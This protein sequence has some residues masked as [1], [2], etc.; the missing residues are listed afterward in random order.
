MEKVRILGISASPRHA[1][2]EIGVKE[3]L[4]GAAELPDVEIEF[5]AMAG[6][7][8]N[9]CCCV[10]RERCM[11]EGTEENPCPNW[12]SND[13]IVV[14]LRKMAD[15]DGIIFGSPVYLGGVSAQLKM[16]WDRAGMLCNCIQGM[17]LT[18]R[19]KVAGAIA[20]SA[21]RNAGAESVL[22]NIWKMCGMLD[23]IPVG[24]G[25]EWMNRIACWGGV[26]THYISPTRQY[27]S[28]K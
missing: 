4:A 11:A 14:L 15:F 16:L 9:P 1:N 19:N 3:A 23:M 25:P 20:V 8:I 12:G 27:D 13:A 6:K 7:K 10:V 22:L 17:P 24:T 5:Y 18:L 2:T 28:V 26:L 21:N